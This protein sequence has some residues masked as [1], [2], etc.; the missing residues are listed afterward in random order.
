[1]TT[2][3]EYHKKRRNERKKRLIAEK[4]GKCTRCGYNKSISALVFH[5]R[6]ETTKKFNISGN[7]L[8]RNNWDTLIQEAKKCDLLCSNCHAEVHD[9]EGWIHE[10]GKRTPKSL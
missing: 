5:H 7:N 8:N 6:D 1:M 10:D 3:G 9:Q 2:A 4:G